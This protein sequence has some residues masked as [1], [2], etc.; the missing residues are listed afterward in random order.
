MQNN[1]KLRTIYFYLLTGTPGLKRVLLSI[2]WNVSATLTPY[3]GNA[4]APRDT[5]GCSTYMALTL[6]A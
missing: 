5:A 1:P 6:G 4:A 3:W 2:F